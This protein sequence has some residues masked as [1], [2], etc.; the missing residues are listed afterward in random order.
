MRNLARSLA[1]ISV[2]LAIVTMVLLVTS[3]SVQL[4][5]SGWAGEGTCKSVLSDTYDPG[6]FADTIDFDREPTVST[7]GESYT[8]LDSACTNRRVG[9]IGW[10]VQLGLLSAL[11]AALAVRTGL[12]RGIG[13]ARGDA[14][15]PPIDRPPTS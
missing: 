7:F 13:E 8:M 12:R 5:G 14:A 10:A 15:P 1:A 4:S 3:S 9:R 6:D 11:A 2:I